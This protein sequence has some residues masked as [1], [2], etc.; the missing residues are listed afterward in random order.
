MCLA[1]FACAETIATMQGQ[2]MALA[3]SGGQTRLPLSVLYGSVELVG[4]H[5]PGV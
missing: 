5:C 4:E 1:P 3:M 2:Q